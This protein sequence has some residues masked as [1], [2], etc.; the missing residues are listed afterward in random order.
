MAHNFLEPN[1]RTVFFADSRNY[2]KSSNYLCTAFIDVLKGKDVRPYLSQ[3]HITA[4]IENDGPILSTILATIFT[5]IGHPPESNDW[6][7]FVAI[8]C[9]V[10]A[11]T[12]VLVVALV[13]QMIGSIRWAT[14]TG[15]AFALYPG[16]L[17]ASGRVMTETLSCLLCVAY[18]LLLLATTRR[19][20]WSPLC[21][22]VA[23]LAWTMKVVLLPSVIAG[24]LFLSGLKKLKPAAVV[25]IFAGIV[26]TILPWALF[27]NCFLHR[28]MITTERA[29]V[30][31]AFIGWDT[32]TD[33]F[34]AS[35]PTAKEKMLLVHDPVSVIWGQVLSDPRG[36]TLLMLEKFA[37]YYGQPFNDFRHQCF[38]ISN[39]GLIP[40]HL[41]YIFLGALGVIAYAAGGFRR[42]SD[43][44]R[45]ACNLTLVV[46]SMMQC[47]FLFEANT[48]YGYT[49]FP[50]LCAFGA[51]GLWIC[52]TLAR[53]KNWLKFA[54]TVGTACL[55]TFL[56]ANSE[57]LVKMTEPKETVHSLQ[58]GEKVQAVI[59]LKSP[60]KGSDYAL[61]LVDGNDGLNSAEVR[62]NGKVLP[63]KL[64]S[65]PYFDS[66]RF[67][68]FNLMKECGY[69]L[70]APV[71]KLRQWRAAIVPISWLNMQGKNEIDIVPRELTSIY[72]D[73]RQVYRRY[74]SLD[75]VCVNKLLNTPTDL[76]ARPLEPVQSAG[77]K[78]TFRIEGAG[79]SSY[80]ANESLRIY[81]AF[82]QPFNSSVYRTTVG[83]DKA[84]EQ[85]F[86]Q[87]DFPLLMRVHNSDE[88]ASSK[89]IVSHSVTSVNARIPPFQQAT[90]A[91]IT[92]TGDLRSAAPNGQAGIAISTGGDTDLF[93]ML[94]SL[95][96]SIACGTQ[97]KT[98]TICD[99]VPLDA[100]RGRATQ[101]GIGI[102]PGP[103]PEV[104]GLGP[105]VAGPQVSLK[106]LRLKI[107]PV[108]MLD[109]HGSRLMVY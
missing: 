23:G 18:I 38:G 21:G 28:T 98:F 67:T 83:D 41:V 79:G 86:S 59:E 73:A 103:W 40:I 15:L 93:W 107:E 92:L 100:F 1:T 94:A 51:L 70:K 60:Y 30:H 50:I 37:R 12:A 5:V 45:L 108:S 55:L 104:M 65:L 29:S 74:R 69:G 72:G 10:H 63:D 68:Q 16:A 109:L 11:I 7:I 31:N 54:C 57:T 2:Q 78:K 34:Q 14:A 80:L 76:E 20:I 44:E 88:I 71:Q 33:G 90:H 52:S 66:K 8:Q 48:R 82:V 84:L 97:W 3:P 99:L 53:E 4:R 25:A 106:N 96:Y 6:K 22:F 19:L 105:A 81:L 75:A 58:A 27:S 49:S 17:I 36:T 39:T 101:V 32:E 56:V 61:V 46:L 64:I 87:A 35:F 85:R 24:I 13:L 42:L 47:Y 43:S 91:R 95:P 77:V 62:V 26:L 89:F 102:Y 9:F